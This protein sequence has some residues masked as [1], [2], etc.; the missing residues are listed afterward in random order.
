MA[1]AFLVV[2]LIEW[3]THSLNHHLPHDTP[4]DHGN[5]SLVIDS[6]EQTGSGS[7]S[8]SISDIHGDHDDGDCPTMICNDSRR[9]D[10]QTPNAGH[11]FAPSNL[12]GDVFDERLSIFVMG[13]PPL[14]FP[15]THRLYGPP[16][17]PFH[18]PEIS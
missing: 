6:T 8:I 18:P 4:S 7:A 17:S 10:R 9:H 12:I 1:V 16:V 13:S 3:G 14:K 5:F 11:E 15:V 2:L